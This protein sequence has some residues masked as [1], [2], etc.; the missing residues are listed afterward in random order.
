MLRRTIILFL[1]TVLAVQAWG[2]QIIDSLMRELDQAID[3]KPIYEA[4]K[5]GRI[6]PLYNQVGL[7]PSHEGKF[8]ITKQLFE[9]YRTFSMDTPSCSHARANAWLLP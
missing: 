6:L 4:R 7:A 9:E 1:T 8:E 5:R 3:N 2:S